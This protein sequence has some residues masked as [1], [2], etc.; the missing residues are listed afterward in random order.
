M[1]KSMK[2]KKIKFDLGILNALTND[3]KKQSQYRRNDE[4]TKHIYEKLAQ[5]S[6]KR[7]ITTEFT[8]DEC[9]DLHQALQNVDPTLEPNAE[10]VYIQLGI[11]RKD[12]DGRLAFN[13]EWA[14]DLERN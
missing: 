11:L 1:E 9:R 4:L 12:K 3:Y 10:S 13:P 8:P 7:R 6:A 2:M 5:C 14:G